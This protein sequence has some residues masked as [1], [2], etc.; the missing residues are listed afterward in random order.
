MSERAEWEMKLQKTEQNLGR[1]MADQD[2]TIQKMARDQEEFRQDVPNR[3]SMLHET[4]LAHFENAEMRSEQ[5]QQRQLRIEERI[6]QMPNEFADTVAAIR[7][8]LLA[9]EIP[10]EERVHTN[11]DE[12]SLALELSIDRPMQEATS[13]NTLTEQASTD[14]DWLYSPT[15]DELVRFAEEMEDRSGWEGSRNWLG[16]PAESTADMMNISDIDVETA[17]MSNDNQSERVE[18]PTLMKHRG[19][20]AP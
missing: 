14:E 11:N 7:R 15:D 2:R 6:S 12:A 8:S 17:N 4:I 1:Q 20:T 19:S 3:Q 5:A 9:L 16:G 13:K 18:A 10:T